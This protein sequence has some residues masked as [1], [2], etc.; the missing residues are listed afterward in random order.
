MLISPLSGSEGIAIRDYS[1]TQPQ[2]TVMNAGSGALETTYGDPS[3]G[4]SPSPT[5]T[6]P[7]WMA[8]SGKQA[9]ATTPTTSSTTR[10]L[11]RSVKIIPSFTRRSWD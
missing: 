2:I 3:A 6:A 10:R 8:R 4:V 9:S 1:K 5:S 11:Q 7:I